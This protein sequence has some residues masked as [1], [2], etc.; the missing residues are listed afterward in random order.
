MAAKIIGS[1]SFLIDKFIKNILFYSN[2]IF[3]GCL[4][5]LCSLFKCLS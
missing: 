3:I 1:E 5:F 4:N 2:C